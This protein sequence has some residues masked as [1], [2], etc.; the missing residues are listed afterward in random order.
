[1]FAF[2]SSSV[3][4]QATL[5]KISKNKKINNMPELQFLAA[6][7]A[8]GL[9]VTAPAIGIGMLVSKGLEAVGRNPEASGKITTMMVLGMAFAEALG[10]Y[11]L[12]ISLIILFK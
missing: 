9:G 7:L 2:Y 1:V 8:I 12:V 5:L 11:A 4:V 3:I 10:I 6:A